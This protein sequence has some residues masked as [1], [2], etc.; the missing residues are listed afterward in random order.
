MRLT[1]TVQ[2][3]VRLQLR[4]GFYYATALVIIFSV[5]ILQVL[6][7]EFAE[8]LLPVIIL[9]NVVTNS[10][11]FV[12]GLI[13]LEHGEGTLA[14]QTITPLRRGEY[15]A[16]KVLTLAGI[17]LAESL[18]V[19]VSVLGLDPGLAL[20]AL[21]VA[22]SS[23]LLT[24][25]GVGFVVRYRSINEFL[26]PSVPIT[27]ALSLPIMG[28]YGLGPAWLYQWHP[29][30]GPMDLMGA[31]V[32]PLSTGRLVFSIVWPALCVIPVYWWSRRAL[33]RSV[34]T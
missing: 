13:L 26:M 25:F 11:Y 19:A 34:L 15:L 3:D 21:G 24:L 5:V 12:A 27:F 2:C 30:Q 9:E 32:R 7:R 22:L 33:T 17:S 6:P 18:I 1:A 23:V 29:L 4:N 31:W 16:S 20:L 14:A 8:A 28:W 10:F